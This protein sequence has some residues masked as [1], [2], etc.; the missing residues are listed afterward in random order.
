MKLGRRIYCLSLVVLLVACSTA[1]S[2][3]STT[4]LSNPARMD[5]N[6]ITRAEMIS[7][8]RG[9][10]YEIISFLRPKWMTGGSVQN[11]NSR[12]NHG[13]NQ[14]PLTVYVDNVKFGTIEALRYFDPSNI[15]EIRY[16]DSSAA[17]QRWGPGNGA[18][19]L[20]LTTRRMTTVSEP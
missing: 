1:Q 15:H 9:N 16:Y 2:G 3:P 6:V 8:D 12:L 5:P 17:A 13:Q 11:L 19:A 14:Q 18:G 4:V 20:S 7:V 10:A